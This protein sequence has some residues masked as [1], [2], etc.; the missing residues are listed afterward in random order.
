MAFEF[1]QTALDTR[2]ES[3]LLRQRTEIASSVGAL[4]EVDGQ[5]FLN[6]SSN[7]YLGM[8][9]SLEVMQAWVT[10]ISEL[11]N[12]SGASPLVTGYSR[13]HRLLEDYLA[14]SLN[15]DKV[16]L[17]NSGFAANQAICQALMQ[18]D[19]LII[20]D[21]YIHAS[22][23]DGAMASAGQFKRYKHNDYA[24]LASLLQNKP[25]DT[26]IATEGVFSMDG[27]QADWTQLTKL[28]EDSGSWL[29]MDDAH[30]LGV[31]GDSGMGSCQTHGLSQQQVPVLMGTFGKAVGTSGAFV[32]GSDTLIDYLQNFSRH[33]VYSTAMPPAQ[34]RATLASLEEIR[35]PERRHQLYENITLFRKLASHAGLP[36]MASDT[37]IQPIVVGEP[38]KAMLASEKLNA[39]GLW[40]TAIRSPTV[41]VGT[42]RLRVTLSASHQPQDIHALVD[43]LQIVWS[44]LFNEVTK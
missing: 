20:A 24:H 38:E 29:M 28:A 22:F 2:R 35:K 18:K 1:M 23:I 31:L 39:L 37:A 26:L 25:A 4:I 30:G 43:G 12:G 13:E 42:D 33:Y 15:R 21:K 11:G 3:G 32:A 10:G 44:G 5:H 6:F 40:V 34:A 9:Q 41:P 36:L 7:D 19:T 27:D 8:R 14:Q 16:M 17:F